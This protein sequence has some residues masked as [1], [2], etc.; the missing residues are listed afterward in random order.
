M[1]VAVVLLIPVLEDKELPSLEIFQLLQEIV[2]LLPLLEMELKPRME[3]LVVLESDQAD[4]ALLLVRE[5]EVE[6]VQRL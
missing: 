6:V 2:S 3:V 5:L 1:E 4:P